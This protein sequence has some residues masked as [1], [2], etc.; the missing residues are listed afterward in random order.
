MFRV[1]V[2]DDMPEDEIWI[3]GGAPEDKEQY[4][5]WLPFVSC[6]KGLEFQSEKE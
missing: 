2:V 1:V 3:I 4:E 5:N 6:L